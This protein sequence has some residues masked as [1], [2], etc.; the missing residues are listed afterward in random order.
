MRSIRAKRINEL[1]KLK[2]IRDA[3]MYKLR[4]YDFYDVLEYNDYSI[5]S[6]EI[7]KDINARIRKLE[8]KLSR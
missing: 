7:V 4:E 2:A 6:Y 5:L 1:R 8:D 3:V